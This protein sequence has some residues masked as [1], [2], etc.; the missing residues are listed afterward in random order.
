MIY[1]SDLED[2][3]D[4]IIDIFPDA[5][6]QSKRKSRHGKHPRVITLY[7]WVA[8]DT[9]GGAMISTKWDMYCYII[10]DSNSG[11]EYVFAESDQA[12]FIKRIKKA[13]KGRKNYIQKMVGE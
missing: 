6:R 1:V 7:Y 12:L 5:T 8:S 4:E 9:V 2:V 13:Y 11:C 10:W 3:I